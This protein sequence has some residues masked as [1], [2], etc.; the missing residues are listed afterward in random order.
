MSR[1]RHSRPPAP[2]GDEASRICNA[3]IGVADAV[4]RYQREV[5]RL[6][7][8]LGDGRAAGLTQDEIAR[9]ASRA[10]RGRQDRAKAL[11]AVFEGISAHGDF[12]LEGQR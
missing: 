9:A 6:S 5:S 8:A 2:V 11:G 1:S 10:G 4:I 3:A 12:P 7:R